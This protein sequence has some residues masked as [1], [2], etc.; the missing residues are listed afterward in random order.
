M[1]NKSALIAGILA[2]LTAPASIGATV[3]YPHPQGND[4][5]RLRGDVERLGR[6]F[7]TV[8]KR[9]NGKQKS[10]GKTAARP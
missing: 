4:L 3:A 10:A 1:Q 7:S 8:I 2:G 9:E 6:D 5:S